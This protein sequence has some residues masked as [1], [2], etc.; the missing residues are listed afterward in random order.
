MDSDNCAREVDQVAEVCDD[1]LAS[2]A[3]W[4]FKPF[5]DLT[6]SAGDRSEGFYNKDG[7][8]EVSKVKSLVRTYVKMAQGQIEEMT[9]VP[10]SAHNGKAPGTFHAVIKVDTSIDA[11]TEIHALLDADS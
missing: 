4:E 2:W 7:S 8:L 5:H 9:F 6:T 3:Y 10:D 1:A 11:P